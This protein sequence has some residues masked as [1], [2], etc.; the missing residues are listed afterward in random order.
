L[1]KV[2]STVST[3]GRGVP[4]TFYIAAFGLVIALPALLFSAFLLTR[5]ADLE[6][7]RTVSQM[8]NIA[9][10]LA[11]G[12]DRELSNSVTTL[13]VLASSTL[14]DDRSYAE[15][16]A[17]ATQALS[18]TD[19]F[20]LLLDLDYQQLLN[21][22]VPY[23]TPLGLTSDPQ[24]VDM[25][26]E[27]HGLFVS[28]I[29]F[30]NVAGQRVFNVAYPVMRGGNILG[31]LIL[32]RDSDTLADWLDFDVIEPWMKVSI[33]DRNGLIMTQLPI[34]GEDVLGTGL[35]DGLKQMA[36]NF[37]TTQGRWTDSDG[38]EF[39]VLVSQPRL[40]NW[41]IV[42]QIPSSEF[43]KTANR[44]WYLLG[45]GGLI[46]LV[47]S[48]VL[49]FLLGSY[50]ARP[51]R[52]LA[53]DARVF[54]EGHTIAE[55]HSPLREVNLVSNLLRTAAI[56][57]SNRIAQVEV[58]MKELAHRAKNQLTIVQSLAQL[59]ARRSASIGD[60]QSR[61][62]SRLEGLS[63]SIDVLTN[64]DWRGAGLRE[65]V[66]A[67]LAVFAAEGGP[68]YRLTGPG[69][70]VRAAA[71]E[72]LGMALHELGTNAA[73][74]GALSCPSGEVEVSWQVDRVAEPPKVVMEW[75][76]TGG[77]A[78]SEPTETGFGHVLIHDMMRSTLKAEVSISYEVQGL[79]WRMT[80]DI[81]QLTDEAPGN[82][83][84]M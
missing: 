83:R 25:A 36:I 52:R 60:F 50:L 14:L 68:R 43:D 29:F 30:G 37:Q 78:V 53:R 51:I 56:E 72:R 59:V 7:S 6:H 64:Q 44:S 5:Y 13:K 67:H 70:L 20:V 58:L 45:M 49:A 81:D 15:F 4:L 31:V 47:L 77:P 38:E 10:T 82:G 55:R 22:R 17:R 57:R 26:V 23:G 76:E 9:T 46:L 18:G 84:A 27:N 66:T 75:R 12:V 1:P 19:S 8:R 80:C 63:R 28:D 21:T 33:V 69:I 24:S 35:P 41:S 65:L 73:K 34:G 2:S 39:I 62:F 32:T 40:T 74:Y 54:G 3:S 71:V 11:D 16:H 79:V 61:F 48:I 42:I